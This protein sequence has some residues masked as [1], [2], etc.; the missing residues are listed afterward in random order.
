MSKEAL[1]Y[2]KRALFLIPPED[3]TI[4]GLDTSD[5]REHPLWDE[6]IKYRIKPELVLSVA[7][8][9][10]IEPITVCKDGDRILVVNGRQRVRAAREV[11]AELLKRGEPALALPAQYKRDDDTALLGAMVTTN[12]HR[13]DDDILVKAAKAQRLYDR[14]M[15]PPDIGVKFGKTGQTIRTWLTLNAL[16]PQLKEAFREGACTMA[17]AV[18]HAEASSDAQKRA[19]IAYLDAAEGPEDGGKGASEQRQPTPPRV[20]R[21]RR[22]ESTIRKAMIG[23]SPARTAALA[24]VLDPAVT[25]ADLLAED[26]SLAEVIEALAWVLGAEF[27]DGEDA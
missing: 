27:E 19:G 24:F 12:E 14:G 10:V 21:K 15:S 16:H 8:D 25:V 6:R 5:G 9:G 7:A 1:A 20:R 26:E 22:S 4:I 11:N 23:A 17:D 3:V 13:T 2:P 18:S